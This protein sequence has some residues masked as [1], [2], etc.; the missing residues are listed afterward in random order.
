MPYN[1]VG[2]VFSTLSDIARK[3][4]E[5]MFRISALSTRNKG[6]WDGISWVGL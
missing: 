4:E 1:K 6:C 3:C 5:D 2:A